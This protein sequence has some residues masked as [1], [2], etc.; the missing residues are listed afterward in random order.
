MSIRLLFLI[1][2]Y[3]YAPLTNAQAQKRL[4]GVTIDDVKNLDQITVSLEKLPVK[5]TTRI[6]F[7]EHVPAK[8]YLT[9]T[10]AIS[11][12]S[13]VMGELLDS[14]YMKNY[15]VS[16]YKSRVSDYLNTLDDAVDIWEIGNEINGDWLGSPESVVNKL[17]SAFKL[18]HDAG[19]TSAV[20]LYYNKFCYSDPKFEMF[21]WVNANMPASM[22]EKLDYVFV[23]YYED[24]CEDYQPDWQAVFDSLHVLF[25]NSKLG[26][27]ECGTKFKDYKADYMTRYYKMRVSTPNFVGGYFWWY[28]RQDCVPYTKPLWAVIN[29]LL[30]STG[31]GMNDENPIYWNNFAHLLHIPPFEG[32]KGD[33][34]SRAR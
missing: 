30:S 22:R 29:K 32:G 6:V 17:N 27:G 10:A 13:Y 23:S 21:T 2:L 11:E 33:D 14:Y 12:V 1:I 19:K 26:I 3:M 5:P 4:Y 31:S 9:A 24:D 28:Y 8:D 7:D 15:S 25:P 16:D 34:Q 20:T 18:V